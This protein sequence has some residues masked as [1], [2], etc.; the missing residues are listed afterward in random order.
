MNPLICF[1]VFQA[2]AKEKYDRAVVKINQL[3]EERDGLR[4]KVDAQGDEINRWV[5]SARFC[6][7]SSFKETLRKCS[8]LFSGHWR[9]YFVCF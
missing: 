8:F 6:V 3:K 4:R 5:K 9:M 1:F 7:S 2:Q